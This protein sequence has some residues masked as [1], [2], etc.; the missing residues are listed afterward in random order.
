MFWALIL[1]DKA[2]AMANGKADL[3]FIFKIL[4]RPN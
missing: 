1:A 3:N 4:W 2:M